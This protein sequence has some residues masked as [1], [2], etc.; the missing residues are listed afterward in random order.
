M[1]EYREKVVAWGSAGGFFCK[2]VCMLVAG[3]AGSDV[4]RMRAKEWLR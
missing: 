3:D 2:Y 1:T 4:R